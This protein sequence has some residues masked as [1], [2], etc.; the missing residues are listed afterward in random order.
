MKMLTPQLLL[1]SALALVSCA[2]PMP[3]RRN[4]RPNG[5]NSNPKF[6]VDAEITKA[7]ET[8][9]S[10]KQDW[11]E[12][13]KTL[14]KLQ[15]V[16][17]ALCK[18]LAEYRT[19]CA[20][21]VRV[22][23]STADKALQCQDNYEDGSSLAHT[24][25]IKANAPMGNKFF[26]LI[27]DGTYESSIF[28]D[29]TEGVLKWAKAGD[30]TTLAPKLRALKTMRIKAAEG[31]MPPVSA[32]SFEVRLDNTLLF[33]QTSIVT[34]PADQLDA[35]Y[36][37]L[38]LD[39]IEQLR[40]TADCMLS[41]ENLEAVVK[42]A[43]ADAAP[44][45]DNLEDETFGQLPEGSTINEKTT[46]LALQN[47]ITASETKIGE[48]ALKNDREDDRNGKLN[49][50]LMSDASVGCF[51]EQP[52]NSM[53][54]IIGGAHLA[55]DPK[56]SYSKE[57]RPDDSLAKQLNFSFGGD[58]KYP[59]LDEETNKIIGGAALKIDTWGQY[60]VKDIEFINI[61][62]MG[63]GWESVYNEWPTWGGL[64]KGSEYQNHE[65]F[66]YQM[67]SVDIKINGQLFYSRTGLNQIL[68]TGS[69]KW[70]D[71]NLM[72]NRAYRTL[73]NRT[74]VCSAK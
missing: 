1:L 14:I 38:K 71:Q 15:E 41:D 69:L 19:K 42:K 55:I 52:I 11:I 20:P 64:G 17:K 53:E 39:R 44:T 72:M 63:I 47:V 35:G 5:E 30:K 10:L 27:A 59:H 56:I 22:L 49:K 9:A 67:T 60:K 43:L 68:R 58:L 16:N 21:T 18:R 66:M 73:M 32:M 45:V 37:E 26:Y 7:Q 50:E 3:E 6:N 23:D 48:L 4:V 46:L 36:Y 12:K 29:G 61:E 31:T 34:P 28:A 57:K 2:A 40:K 24:F 51:A 8:L 25:S 54:I 62:K 70:S 65:R 13:N 74:D 33:D